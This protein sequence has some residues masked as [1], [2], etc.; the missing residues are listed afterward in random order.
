LFPIFFVLVAGYF[1]WE[2][3]GFR[4]KAASFPLLLGTAV[5]ILAVAQI[6]KNGWE[7]GNGDVMDLGMLSAGVEGRSRSAAILFG[8]ICSFLVL[9]MIIGLDYAA[10]TLAAVSPAALMVGKR[11]WAWGFLTGGIIAGAVVF[12]FDNLMHIIWP[13]PILWTWVLGA[14]F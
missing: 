2:G 13:E 5:I 12:V 3:L 11:P 6:V 10:I 8:L 4:P 7:D 1:V 9:A 14:L